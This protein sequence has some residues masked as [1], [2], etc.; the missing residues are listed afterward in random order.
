ME[1]L[2]TI[3]EISPEIRELKMVIAVSP[4]S[5][6]SGGRCSNRNFEIPRFS[7]Y[8]IKKAK[9]NPAKASNVG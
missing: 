8:N 5:I 6:T 2:K 4:F 7:R 3:I 1:K 9:L